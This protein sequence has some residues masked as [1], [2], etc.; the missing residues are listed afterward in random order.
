MIKYLE[1]YREK[2]R[3]LLKD[4]KIL[5]DILNQGE[6]KA[7]EVAAETIREVKE[8]LGLTVQI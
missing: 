6:R 1:P 5:L 8:L 7:R 2:K 4:K 3:E